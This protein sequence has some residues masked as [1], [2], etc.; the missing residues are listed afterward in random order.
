M[1]NVF[2]RAGALAQAWYNLVTFRLKEHPPGR[3]LTKASRKEL[4]S[5]QSPKSF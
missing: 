4:R 3:T 1:K 2:Q 5:G